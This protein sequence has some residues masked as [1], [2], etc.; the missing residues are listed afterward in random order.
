MAEITAKDFVIEN[1]ISNAIKIPLVKVDRNNFLKECFATNKIKK[2]Q[3]VA[4]DEDVFEKIEKL[5]KLKD[6][7][8]L[9]EE[10]FNLKKSE[11]LSKI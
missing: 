5:T 10:E 3:T 4:N 7:G 11:L 8:A 9:T 6:M 1:V 2:E